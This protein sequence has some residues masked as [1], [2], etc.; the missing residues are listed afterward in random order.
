[1]KRYLL[2]LAAIA[3]LGAGLSACSKPGA[4]TATAAANDAAFADFVPAEAV[5]SLAVP[6]V[7]RARAA[8]K[9]SSIYKIWME[10]EMQAFL[11][12]PLA[13]VPQSPELNTLLDKLEAVQA[14]NVFISLISLASDRP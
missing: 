13:K 6:D 1:M 7:K 5:V 11:T 8:W 9:T 4:P 14:R 2:P 12:K 10:P 3:L